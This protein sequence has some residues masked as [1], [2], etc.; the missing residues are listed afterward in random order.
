MENQEYAGG[1]LRPF[2]GRFSRPVSTR[3][4]ATPRRPF[5]AARALVLLAVAIAALTGARANE[6]SSPNATPVPVSRS[7][8]VRLWV[9]ACEC[10]GSSAVVPAGVDLASG[11]GS[12]I[13]VM[14]AA[15]DPALVQLLAEMERAGCEG[16][17]L[18]IGIGMGVPIPD[19]AHEA[20][21]QEVTA[22]DAAVWSR[23]QPS[24]TTSASLP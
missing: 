22:Q 17:I 16:S 4:A 1:F 20:P 2:Q 18:A 3:A 7:L 13:N 10:G 11:T 21:P 8:E 14:P 19:D 6:A 15:G 5:R 12:A 9:L 23:G 24:A